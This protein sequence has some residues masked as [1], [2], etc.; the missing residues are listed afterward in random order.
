M[1]DIS[2]ISPQIQRMN[3]SAFTYTIENIV[4]NSF[5][6]YV[7]DLS[8]N[9]SKDIQKSFLRDFEQKVIHFMELLKPENI[10]MNE[11]LKLQEI[12]Q[13][14]CDISSIFTFPF[15]NSVW[16]QV[17]LLITFH[18]TSKDERKKMLEEKMEELVDTEDIDSLFFLGKRLL[19]MKDEDQKATF[20]TTFDHIFY[21]FLL[22]IHQNKFKDDLYDIVVFLLDS[23]EDFEKLTEENTYYEEKMQLHLALLDTDISKQ[24]KLKAI[25]N[26][27]NQ[28][29]SFPSEQR[30][31]LEFH[32]HYHQILWKKANLEEELPPDIV[33][34][35]IFHL[36]QSFERKEEFAIT[37]L[38]QTKFMYYALHPEPFTSIHASIEKIQLLHF[39]KDKENGIGG[40]IEW[41]KE[42]HSTLI[43]YRGQLPEWAIQHEK[44][45]ILKHFPCIIQHQSD[46]F[47]TNNITAHFLGS[48]YSH[49]KDHPIY[50]SIL[51]KAYECFQKV[52]AA[53]PEDKY[54]VIYYSDLTKDIVLQLITKGRKDEADIYIEKVIQA[55]STPIKNAAHNISFLLSYANFMLFAYQ[56]GRRYHEKES[57]EIAQEYFEKALIEGDGHYDQPYIGLV[58]LA[59]L[60]N[61][62]IECYR[63][64]KACD[65]NFSN[66]N[67]NYSF[68]QFLET[69]YF[70]PIQ[71]IIQQ[72]ISEQK[73]VQ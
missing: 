24:D 49:H 70:K 57:L 63:Q 12:S 73:T 4:P 6:N 68:S 69:P 18:E 72:I 59:M 10:S 39:Q 31:E 62:K 27:I 46:D 55:Y 56:N 51:T 64:L 48:I 3:M 71:G 21:H 36:K 14:F 28:L 47:K 1:S 20:T 13:L 45:F 15:S 2:L 23:V 32:T 65:L 52:L 50:E 19:S 7:E 41:L 26:A 40:L 61:D 43:R 54:N 33:E 58:K 9:A 30:Q 11:V 38:I 8:Y 37:S 5:I 66:E 67:Y 34:E 29:K 35:I 16:H 44:G 42:I 25:E 22:D 17:D 53:N 60:K